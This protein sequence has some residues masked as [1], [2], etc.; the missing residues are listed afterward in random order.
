MR[1]H[2]QRARRRGGQHQPA[3][4]RTVLEGELLR[5]RAAPRHAEHVGLVVSEVIEQPGGEARDARGPIRRRRRRRA[6][7]A[8]N[9]EDDDRR[10]GQRVDERQRRARCWRRCRSGSAAARG[11]DRR[12][13]PHSGCDGRG[14]GRGRYAWR[15][16][17]RR[18]SRGTRIVVTARA[19]RCPAPRRAARGARCPARR[20]PAA[21]C[22]SA[23]AS[24]R[25]SAA[26][27]FLRPSLPR[28]SHASGVAARA[29]PAMNHE[30][31]LPG[32]LTRL[33]MC[34]PFDSTNVLR[35]PP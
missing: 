33:W 16:L 29:G 18:W 3:A 20:A 21:A 19:R 35:A 1:R 27:S 23:R 14:C 12:G 32:G 13:G 25:A 9:V 10:P 28:S 31:A 6:A 22:P 7:H 15:A 17:A 8:G 5:D 26:T 11:P 24:T 2:H 34:P 30:R 4:A